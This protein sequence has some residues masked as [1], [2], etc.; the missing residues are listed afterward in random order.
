M[1]AEILSPDQRRAFPVAVKAADPVRLERAPELDLFLPLR[2]VMRATSLGKT[3]IYARIAAGTFPKPIPL[4]RTKVAW[5][6]RA[7]AKWQREITGESG[8]GSAQPAN[9]LAD[10]EDIAA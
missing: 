10:G 8:T 1:H 2:E 5:S 9:R 6:A 3:A 7:L 4:S